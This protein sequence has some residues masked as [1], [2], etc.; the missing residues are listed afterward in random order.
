[1][2]GEGVGEQSKTTVNVDKVLKTRGAGR[3][4]RPEDE[5]KG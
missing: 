5:A 3:V 2:E 1:M 4:V